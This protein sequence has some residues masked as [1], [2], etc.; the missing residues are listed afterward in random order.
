MQRNV[1]HLSAHEA[2]VAKCLVAFWEGRASKQGASAR[3]RSSRDDGRGRVES[4]CGQLLC[5]WGIVCL[6]GLF[7]GEMR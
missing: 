3:L 1:C 2:K 4:F 6:C 7:S 5:A